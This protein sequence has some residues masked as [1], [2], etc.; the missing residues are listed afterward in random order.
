MSSTPRIAVV[1]AGAIGGV[2]AAALGDCGHRVTLCAR[3]PFARLTRIH[4]GHSQ[5]YDHPV[6][7]RP[8][9]LAH[10]DW[11]F[12]CTKTYQIQG[13]ANW[14]DALVGPDTRIAVMQN[15]VDHVRR[16]SAFAPPE[17]VVP[18]IVVLAGDA[19]E[20]GVIEQPRAGVVKVPATDAGHELAA[21]FDGDTPVT[22]QPTADFTTEVWRKLVINAAG[23]AVCTLTLT[24]I[25]EFCDL[26]VRELAEALMQEIVAVGR[27][28]GANIGDEVIGESFEMLENRAG[29][30]WSSISV[31]W[32]EGRP[33]EWD[34]RNAVVGRLGRVHGIPTPFNDAVTAL[35]SL[36]DAKGGRPSRPPHIESS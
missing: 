18:G 20:P 27:A 10:C 17:R 15:G 12:L 32:R 31:D 19:H 36:A 29:A 16:V 14:L 22:V 28:E 34:A 11:L 35:L 25:R 23:G 21:L 6:V 8:E 3:T 1:G 2:M 33:M 26:R 7:T 24:P 30:H 9:G 13:A 4:D 5:S